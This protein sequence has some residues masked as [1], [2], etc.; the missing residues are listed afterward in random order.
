LNLRQR[1]ELKGRL[2]T[3][4]QIARESL[5]VDKKRGTEHDDKKTEELQLYVGGKVL[6]YDKTVRLGRL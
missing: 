6:P 2:Q 3:P 1:S 4:H 5:I